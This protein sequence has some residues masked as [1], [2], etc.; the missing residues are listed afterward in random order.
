M[1]PKIIHPRIEMGW[2]NTEAEVRILQ[3]FQTVKTALFFGRKIAKIRKNSLKSWILQGTYSELRAISRWDQN[4]YSSSP[5]WT[6]AQKKE[7]FE[8][9]EKTLRGV[10][11]WKSM[12]IVFSIKSC[13]DVVIFIEIQSNLDVSWA[14]DWPQF[15][16]LRPMGP[17]GHPMDIPSQFFRHVVAHSYCFNGQQTRPP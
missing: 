15:R 8:V 3:T 9:V 13:L 16:A 10:Y 11:R 5:W 1:C 14:N 2:G 6:I 4:I 12:T 7:I 17:L